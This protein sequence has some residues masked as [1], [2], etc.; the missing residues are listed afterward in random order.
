MLDAI[1]VADRTPVTVLERQSTASRA[2]GGA[3]VSAEVRHA[4]QRVVDDVAELVAVAF[5][6]LSRNKRFMNKEE[7][8]CPISDR[9]SRKI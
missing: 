4:H 9:E 1:P 7:T 3:R 5:E 8:A 6:S 2:R